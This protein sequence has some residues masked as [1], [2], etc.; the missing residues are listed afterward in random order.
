M[1]K[2]KFKHPEHLYFLPL[3]GSGEIGMNMN[4]YAYQNKWLMV[5][6][7]ITFTR[8]LGIE[9]LMPDPSFIAER[10]KDLVGLVLT[11]AHEDHIGA[12]PYL[13]ERLRCP[14]FA[15]P[16]TAFLVR[17]KLKEVGLLKQA[18]VTEVPLDSEITLDPFKIR[19][20][21][22]THSIPEPNA[23]AISTDAGTVIHTGDWK[24]DPEPFV[25]A[26]TDIKTL[27]QYG[28]QG[29]LALVCDSTN[30]FVHGRTGSEAEVRSE[31]AG[32][33]AQ[34]KNRVVVAC[35]ASNVARVESAALAGQ[36]AGRKVVLAGRSL[37]RMDDAA[38]SCG[39]MKGMPKFLDEDKV[40]GLR[41]DET[42][43]I[44]TGSQGEPRSALAR[45]AS[46]QHPRIKL[47]AGD[48]VIFSSRVIPGNEDAIK[49]L[50]NQLHDLGVHV[51][52]DH[53]EEVHVSG[54]PARDEL[55]DMYA[56]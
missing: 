19:Y 30:A 17:E 51:I 39:Y 29:V 4:L 40:K 45:I 26:Q 1:T 20:I 34:Q 25:G 3:G 43:I 15:T 31:L 47:D 56:W 53:E 38:R 41:R 35:F 33:I 24:I 10:R 46:G 21:T 18:I 16:F 32:L 55:K 48:T 7:G 13:W 5:D 37:F 54:H 12:V 9:V 22:L 44:C 36:S 27:S 23:L 2:T 49:V 42:L 11:H 52:T 50:Q 14:I 6:C 28:D 8:D